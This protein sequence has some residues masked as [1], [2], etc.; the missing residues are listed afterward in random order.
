MIRTR[1][2][3]KH[4]LSVDGV[5]DNRSASRKIYDFIFR[6]EAY[7]IRSYLHVLRHF[8]YYIN[9]R[10]SN[11]FNKLLYHYYGIRYRMLSHKMGL[12]LYP[13]TVGPG[14][15]LFHTYGGK[16]GLVAHAKVGSHVIFRPGVILGYQGDSMRTSLA[17][18]VVD[19]YVEFSWNVKVFGK[20]H[21]GRGALLNTGCVP[22]TNVPPYAIVAGN[23]GKVIGFTKTP[24]EIVEFEKAIYPP[25]ERLSRELLDSNYRKYFLSRISEIRCEIRSRL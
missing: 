21:I 15:Q 19:D 16:T 14:V 23:P 1:E 18:P 25:E 5:P 9:N 4:Y 22:M 17:A 2:D 7:Y 20:I 8:E 13:N 12:G 6:N 24:E 11:L 3:L 10:G